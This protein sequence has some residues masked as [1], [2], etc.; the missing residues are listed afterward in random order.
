MNLW[1]GDGGVERWVEGGEV[2]GVLVMIE[3]VSEEV[4]GL[5]E[6]VIAGIAVC[7]G[8]LDFFMEQGHEA[9]YATR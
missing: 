1:E 4:A 3:G 7:D 6:G 5:N 9:A 8:D 2:A